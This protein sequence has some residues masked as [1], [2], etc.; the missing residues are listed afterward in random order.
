MSGS[1]HHQA[2]HV[3]AFALELALLV[4][5]EGVPGSPAALVT[6]SAVVVHLVWGAALQV[7]VVF[8]E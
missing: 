4:G 1:L 6:A 8:V 3:L 2:V 5:L 7:E